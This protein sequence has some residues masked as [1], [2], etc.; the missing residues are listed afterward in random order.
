MSR[1]MRANRTRILGTSRAGVYLHR[2]M[3]G[4]RE[5]RLLRGRRVASRRL[6]LLP[7]PAAAPP[8]HSV[9]MPMRWPV[10]THDPHR[11]PP[12]GRSFHG[13]FVDHRLCQERS[14]PYPRGLDLRP[15]RPCLW[16]GD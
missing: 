3:K 10:R 1:Q 9:K 6:L 11:C 14:R 2:R 12:V 15:V 4:W 5:V 8:P 16:L 7:V 13:C